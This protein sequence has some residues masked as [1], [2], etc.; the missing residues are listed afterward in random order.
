MSDPRTPPEE[1]IGEPEGVDPDI[2][3]DY[4]DDPVQKQEEEEA[5]KLLDADDSKIA[6]L[7]P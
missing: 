5:Q 6:P 7:E 4:D 3:P 1:R 2:S